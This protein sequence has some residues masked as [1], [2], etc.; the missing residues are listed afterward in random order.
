MSRVNSGISAAHIFSTR[1]LIVLM[2]VFLSLGLIVLL[3]PVQTAQAQPDLALPETPDAG[4]WV[5]DGI[6]NAM[7]TDGV[8]TYI[9]GSFNRVGPNT[10]S[11]VIFDGL[12]NDPMSPYLRINNDVNASASDGSGGWYIGGYFN[13]VGGMKRD[14]VAHIL[15]DGSLDQ[16]WNPQ[17]DG[18]INSIAVGGGIVYIAGYFNNVGGQ[19]R[20]YLAA[21]DAGTGAVTSWDPNPNS[22]VY[23]LAVGGNTVYAAGYFS[24]IGGQSRNYLAAL[25]SGTGAATAWDPSPNS[26]V[27]AL[28]VDGNTVYAGG[29][30]SSIGGQPRNYLAALDAGTGAAT[31]WDPSP[32]SNIYSITVSGGLVYVCG[33][34]GSVGGQP[35]NYM[36]AL[37]ATTGLANG[38]NPSPNYSGE[39]LLVV[40]GGTVYAGGFFS[41]IGGQSRNYLAALDPTTGAA[42][43]W[44]PNPDS[45]VRTISAAGGMFFVGGWFGSVGGVYR[46]CLAALDASGRPTDWNPG[47]NSEVDALEFADGLVYVGGYFNAVG[48]QPRDHLAAID[49]A[50]GSATAWDPGA[51]EV[52]DSL[53]VADGIVYAGGYFQSIG[54]K[55]RN[56]LAALDASSGTATAWNPKPDNYVYDVVV[57]GG[58]VYAGGEFTNIGGQP[59][60]H[61][62][63]LDTASGDAT[64]WNPNADDAVTCLVANNGLVYTGGFFAHVGGQTRYNIAALDAATGM[65]TGWNP[66]SDSIIGALELRGDTVYAGGYF[67]YIGNNQRFGLAAVDAAGNSTGWNPNKDLEYYYIDSLGG[68]RMLGTAAG[69]A[70]AEDKQAFRDRLAE[71]GSKIDIASSRRGYY[72]FVSDFLFVGDTLYVSGW[73]GS[74]GYCSQ[75]GIAAFTG[76]TDT[77]YMAEGSTAGGMETWILVENPGDGWVSVD[78]AFDTEKGQVAPPELQGV[79]IPAHSRTSF[80]IGTFLTSYDV[81]TTVTSHGGDVACERALY[82]NGRAWGSSSIGTRATNTAWFLAEGSTAGGMETWVLVQNPNDSGVSVD[83]SFLTSGGETQPSELQ[84]YGIAPHRRIS[85]NAGAYV[86]DYNV[87]TRVVSDGAGVVCERSTYGP[88]DGGGTWATSSM[89]VKGPSNSWYLAEG[90]TDAGR[91]TWVLVENPYDLPVDVNVM[92]LSS[93]GEVQGPIDTIPGKSRRTYDAGEYLTA[94]DVA[95]LITATGGGVICERA[96]YGNARSWATTAVG[97]QVAAT[98]WDLPEG[99]TDGGMQTWILVFNPGDDPATVS[100]AF[101]TAG[102]LNQPP[103]LQDFELP[104]RT[105]VTICVNNYVTSYDVSTHVVATSGVVCERSMYGPTLGGVSGLWATCSEGAY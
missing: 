34:F 1:L 100:V 56:Y 45:P 30:F 55:P 43:A 49:A 75:G 102:G 70:P 37:D 11:G 71:G 28:A 48:G 52:V 63:A 18:Q 14:Y 60:N 95:T 39:N 80:N 77:W 29:Y 92:F 16:G 8:T 96:F 65:A 32:N 51:D 46:G 40:D 89:G 5:V 3:A 17:V 7:A 79:P 23:E 72:G 62:A 38:F 93:Q 19:V 94:G 81:S 44:D 54:G 41:T 57:A 86:A 101:Q 91:E 24:I 50:S 59:R 10:G 58:L 35:R 98:Q 36:A 87:S 78:L 76:T 9:G 4:T 103:E 83:V 20:N 6:V 66:G 47:A 82:G 15:P 73:F 13:G 64:G 97:S 27:Y 67:T 74:I 21:L 69:E 2:T 25:D 33:Y 90:A 42:T 12:S 104:A 31:A 85:I 84:N 88:A 99:S 26:N 22:D 53:A 105:R 68:A 61:L